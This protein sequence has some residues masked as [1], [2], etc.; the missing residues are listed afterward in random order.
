MRNITFRTSKFSRL[1]FI[2]SLFLLNTTLSFAQVCGTPGADGPINASTSINTYYPIT[3]TLNL[4]KGAKTIALTAV[5]AT[6]SHGNNFGGTQISSGDLV[7]IIQMQDASIDYSNNPNYGSG[8]SSSGIDGLGG[9]GFTNLGNTGIYEY[10]IATSNVPLTGGTLT[11]IGTGTGGGALNDY[12]NAAPTTTSGKKTFQIIRVPQF[13]NLTLNSN[14]T[15]PPFNGFAGGIIAFNVSGTFNFNG[16]N[17]DGSARGFRGG[18]SPVAATNANNST[19]YVDNSTSSVVSGKGEGIAGTPRYMWDGF[20]Q[21]NNG[22]EGMPG[23]SAGRGAPANAGGGGNDHN[24]GGGGGGNGGN[25]G[26]GGLGWQ[27]GG[28]DVSPLNGGGR[29]GYTSYLTATPSLTRLVMGGGGGAGDANNAVNGV[30]GG[31]GGAIILINAGSIQGTGNIYA[32]G[33][34]GA[35][36]TYSGAPDGAGGGGAGGSV[37]LNISNNST[38]TI[39]IEAKGGN[40][41]NTLNDENNSHGPG[42]G[43]GGGIIRYNVPGSGVTINTS[44]IN[45]VSGVTADNKNHGAQ[46]GTVGYVSTFSSSDMPSELQINSNCLA[47]LSTKVNSINKSVC[48]TIDATVTYEIEIT[49]LGSGNAAQVNLNYLFPTGINFDSATATYTLNASG[50]TGSMANTGTANSPIVGGF[51]IPLNGVVKITLIG[52]VAAAMT[53]GTTYSS[54]AQA[55]YLDPTRTIAD[56][57]RRITPFTNSFGTVNT[58]YQTGGG[59]NVGGTNFDGTSKTEDDVLVIASPGTPSISASG[60][61]TFCAGG[62]VVLSS[63]AGTGYLWSTGATTQTITV[64]TS[65]TYTVKVSNASGCYSASSAGTTVTANP[66]P[67]AYNVTGGGAYCAGGT[68]VAVGLSNSQTGVSYQ[69]KLA[70][71]NDGTAV[72]GTGSAI[73]FGTKTAAG[74]YTVV[75]TNSTTSCTATMTGSA[76]ISI[77]PLPTAYNVTGG[78]TYCAGGTGFAIGLSNS[79][80]GVSYQLQLGGTNNGTAVAGTGSAISFGTKTAAGTYTVVATNTTTSCTAPMTG[81]ATITVNPLPT[82]YN[83][84]GGGSY[85]TGGTGFAVGLSNSQSGVSYQLKLAGANDG[86]AVAGTGSAISFGT[87]TAAG[88]Y[89]VVATNTTTSC[90]ATMTG[91]ATITINP[92]PTAYNVTGGGAYCAGG[93]GVAV[94]LSNSQTGVSYQLQLAGANDGTAVAGTGSAISFGTKTAAGNYTVVATNTTTSCT[95]PMTGSV[96]ITVN[97]LPT[98]YNVTGGGSYCAGGTGVAVGLSNSQTG[99]SYQLQLA[100]AND[101]TVVAGTGS[102]ISFGTKTAAGNYTVVATNTTTSCTAPM[103]GS[104]TIT[105]NPLP[106]AY[107]VTG[108]GSYCAGGTGVA[109]GL[110]NSQTG[111]SYQLQLAGANDGTAVAGTGSAISFGTKTAAGTYTVVAT[112]TTTSCTAP[113][114]GSVTIT[115]NPLPTTYNVTG[116]GSYCAGG[117]GVAVGLS[118]SQT[119]VSYQ[120]QLAGANDGT[121]V[122]GTG[123]AISFGTKTA[124]GNYTVVATNTTTS[125]TAPM[126]GSVTI[127]INPLP[128]AYNVTGGGSYCAG[129]TGVAVGLSNS[130]TGVSYQLQLA[131]AN[132]GTAVAGTG[133]AISFGTRTAAGNYTV[134]ATNTTT[135]CTAP[136]TGSVTI[137]VNPL[138]TAYNVTGGG[139]YCAG[140]TGVAVG[141]SNSQTG[142]SY[143]LQLAGA[144]DGTAVAGTGSA[145][146]FGTK[147]AAGNYTVVATN[148]TT[149]CTAPMTGSV[150]ITINPLPTAYN[151]TGG[152]AYCAG[153]TGV[154][155]GLSNSQTGVSY[156]LQLAG[157]ND[158]TAVAGTGS[159]ISFGTKTAAGNYTVV[160]TNT[161]TSCTAPMTGSVTITINPLPTAYNVTGGGAYCA[162]GTGVAVGLSNSQ[163]GVSYQLQLAGANDGTAV[164]GTGSAISFGTKTA[165][166]NYT[167]VATNT[168]TSC[169]A[170]MTGSV[171]I[172]VNPLPTAYNVTGGGAYC[173]GGTG[174]AV[175]LSNSQTGVSYQLQL[176]GA[177]DGTAVAGTG[178]AIS[179]GT[180]TAT[181]NYTVVATNSTTSCTAPMSGSVTIS[182][183]PLP[184]KPVTSVTQPN[185]NT[186]TGSI[187]VTVQDPLETYSFDNGQN[188]QSGNSKS[189]LTPGSYDVIIKNTSGCN[190]PKNTVTINVKPN[191]PPV[192]VDD[193]ATATEDTLYTSTVSLVTNDTDVDSSPLTV[194]AGTYTT[195]KG[196]T[197]T[198]AADGSYTYM[199]APNFNG[200]DTVDY[201]VTDGSLTDIG[202]LTITVNAVNDAPIAV[203]DTATATED[204]LY[205]STVSLV[206]NDTDV[207]SSP[208][209][210]I[211]GTYTTT[212]GGTLTLAADGSYTYMPAPN[213]SGTDTVDYTVTDGSLTDIGTLTITVN[214]VNDAPVAVDDTATVTEDTLYTSTVSLVANDTDV[215]SSPLT[216][217]AGTY[218]TTKGG[219]LTLAADGSYTYMPPANFSGTD[220]VDYTVTDG[221]LTDIGTLT[222]TVNAVNDAPIAVD[223]T[224]TATEDTLYTSTV[225]L[226]ANDTDVDSS[227][228]TVIAGTYTTTKGGTLT[229]AA[230][231]SYTYMPAPNFSGTD[232]VDYTVTDGSLTDIGTLTITVNAVNDAPI[233]VDDT[234]TATEDTLYTSIVSLVANDTDVDSSPLTVI[235][236]TY[237]TTKGGTLTLVAD[238][239][240]TYMPAPNFS[241]TDTVDYTVTDGSLTDIGTLTIT[242]NAVND[243]PIAVDDTA[244]ATEDTLYTSTV[245]LVANDT[246]VDSSPLTV[247]AGTYTTTK[248]GTLTLAADGS[249]TYMPAPNFSGTDTVDYTVT[250]GSLTD[251]GTLTITVNAV[252]D[253]PIAVD[254]TA[255]ATEDTLYTSTVSLVA[256]DTDVDSSPLTVIAGTYTTTK[257]GTLTL[258]A[259]GS[260]TYMPAPNFNG[261]DTVDYTVT[262]GSLTDVGALTIT[263]NAVNDAPIAVDD[264]ATATEDTLYTSTVSLVAND[265]DVD[266]SPLTVV[267]G[268]YTTVKGGTLTLAADGSYT[269]MPAPNFNGTDTVDYTVTDGSLTDIGTLTITV[270]AVNDAPIAVDDTAT[271]TEDTLYTST[272]SLVANDTDVDSSPLT[273]IA[274]TYTTTK[275]GT[276]TLAADGSYT[277]MPPA[278]FN[279]TDTVDYTVTDGSL[280]DIGT[281][282]ITVNAVNDAPIAVDDTATA[283]EDTLYTSTVSLVANDTDVDS[284]PL[285]VIAGTYT[286][287]KGGT[288][289]LAA[290]G[291][292]TYMPAPNFN[293][294]DTVDY[295]VTDGSLTDIGTLTI[296]V[297]AVNDAPIA[298]DDT[299]TATED[300]LYTSSISLVANDTDVDS[301]PLTVIAGTYTTAKGG[302]LTLAADGSYTYMPPANFSGT[303]TVDYTVTDG[304]LTDIGTLTIT[305][306]AVND[307]PVAV[308]D[309]ATAT[310]DTLYT[311]TVSLVANDTDVDSSPLTV[312]AGTYTTTKGGT[313]TLAADGSYTYMPAPNFNGTDT[314]DY[315]VTDGSLTD[316][317]T[318]T[319]TVNAVNDAPIA[320]DDT[321]TATEDTLYTSTVSLVANDTD[322][323]SSP[324]T[325]IA[326]TYTTAKGGTLTLAADG[327]YT[328]MPP[329]N[330]SGTDTVDYTVTDGSLT[331]IGTLTITVNAVND[332]PVAVDDTAT[333]TEDTLYT[334]TVS[335]VAN[336]T[337]VDSSPLTVIA[338]TYT[339]TKGGTLTLAA[340]GSYTYMPAPNFNGTDTVDYTVTDG[341]LTDIGTL[342]ITV[343]PVNDAPIAVDDTATATEDTLY[344]SMVSLV[345]NDTDVDSS[346]LTVIAGTYTTA[347]GGTLTLAADGSYTYMPAPNFNGTDT[348]DYTVT[349]GSLTDVGT[350]TI[351]VNAVNDAPIAVDDTA[352]VTEDTLYTS[353]VSLVANDT[354]VDSSPL[355][356]VA[357]TYTTTKGGTLTLAADGSYTYMP[358]PNFNG[359][360]TVDYTVTDGSLTDVGT[361]TITV[362][363]V[364][365]APVAVDDTATA[366]E[367][368]LYTSTVSLVAND[369]DV[370]S[371][372]LTVVAGTYTT[373][374]GG[375]L[376]LA[377]DGSYTYMP[378]PNFNG[379]DTVDY[380]VTDGSLTDIGT[381]TITVNAVNDAPVAVDDTATATEDTLYTS[382]VSLVANDTDVDS[383]PLTVIAGT[384]TTTKGGTLT[385]AADGSYTYMPAPNFNGTDTVDY[386]VTDGSLTDVGTLTIT[387]NAVNDAPV[388]VDDTATAT[389][390]T[391]YTSTVS[392]VANDTDVDSSPLTVVAG[393]YTTTK[394]GTLTL[395]SDGSYTYMPAP[396]FNGTD[397]VDYTVTDGS[398]TDIG[399]LTIT[400]NAVNDAPVAVDDTATATEDTLYTSTVSLVANDTDVDSSPLTVVAGTYTTTKGGTLILAADGSYTYMP[401]ANFSGIDTVDYTVTDGSLTD[402]GTL[403]ITVNAVNH[404]PIAVDNSNTTNEDTTLTV[405]VTSSVNLLANDT[406]SDG[407][408]LTITQFVIGTT[409]Y[410]VGSTANLAEG[411]LTINANGSYTFVPKAD[412]NGSVP[413]V[414]YTV[415]DG[416]TSATANLFIT[417]TPVNDAPIAVDDTATATEDTLY[418]SIVSLVANDTDVDSSPLTVIAGTYTTVKGGTLTLAA[419][420]SYTY[421]P[422]PNFSG[423]DT[424][425]YTVTDGSLT[426]I[427]TLTITVNAVNDAPIAV[428][429]TA[430][431]TEDTLY[432][433]T[434]S[435]VANDTDVDSSPL[436]VIAGTYTT[437]KGG[438]LTLAADGSYTYMPPANFSGTD[439]VDYTV[440]DGS[441]T[442]IGTLTITV[443]AVNHAPIAVDNSNTTNEDTTLTVDVTS[444][445]NLLANDTDADGDT[446]TITQFVI[447]TTTY[448]VGSTANLAEG[449]LTINA[450]G[451]YVFIPKADYNG[452]V[453]KVTYTV[454]DGTSS[455]TANLFITVTPVNDAPIAVDDTATATEDTL[456]TSS[457]SLV[458]ND[459]DVDSSPLTVIAGTYT[460]AKGGTLTLAADGSYTYMPAPNFN[461]TDTVDYTV[462]DGSLTDIGTLTITVNAV[463]DAPIA[464]DDTATAT[465]DTLY[466]STVS[467][468]AND[469]DVDS[470]PLTVVA[471][472]Y[473]TAKGGTLT[474]AADGSYTYMPAPNF[475]GT[476]TVDYTVTDGSLTDV[477]TLTITVTAVNDAPIAVD[478]TATATEDTL[479]TSTVSLV[480]N[481]TDV[482]SSPLTVIAGTYTTVKGGTLTLAADGSYTYM[483]PANFSGTDTVDYTVTDGSLTDIGTLTITVNAV[484]DAPVAVDDTA[485]A[486]EDTLYTSTVSLVANDTDVDSSPLTVIAGTYTTTKGGTL[487]LAADGSYT[488]MPAPNFNGTDTVDYTV[489]DGSLTDIGTLTITV[490]AVN[491]APVAV[492]N[493]NTTNE[494][495]T[496]TVAVTSSANLLANDTDADGDTL[497]ITQ[498]VIGTTTYTVGSTANLA[499]GDLTI[500]ANGSYVFI[501]KADYNGSVPKVTY[502]VTDGTSS[503][504]ANLFITV[505][506]VN[507]APIAVDDTA[508]ATEDTL[509][510][511][512]VSLVA[513]DTDV[514]SSSLTVVA[515][516]Y[517]TAKGGTLTL[518]ADGSYTYM[519]APNFNGTDTVDYTVTDG[520]L[521]DIGTLTITVNAVNDA[522]IAVDDTATATEDTLYTST[523]SLVANDT[524]VDSSPLTVVAGTYTTTKGGTLTLAADGSYTYMP[525]PNFNGTDTVDYTVTDGSL[526]DIG[527]LTITVNAVNDAPIAVDDTATAIEDTLYTSTVSLVANDTDVDSSPLTVV[528]GTY[529]TTKGGTLTLATDG[530]YTYMPAPNFN[531]TDTVD[532]TVTDGSL[533]DIGTLTITVTAVNHAPIAV[534]NSNT[535]NED[536]TLTVDVTSSANLLAND[537]DADGDTLTITQFVIGTTTYPVGSTANLAEGD[538]T[539][540][541]NGSYVFIPKADYNGSVPKVTYT[542]TD[543]TSSATANLF[544]TVTPVNDAP[545]AVDDTATATEDTLYTSS[546]S[547]VANDT[548]VDSSPLTVVA[549][550]YTTT[551]G[552]TLTLA[553]DG[554]YTYMPAPNF[555]GTDTVDYTVTDGSLTDIGTL[556]ITVNAVND[557]PIAVDDTATATEDTLYTSTV[558]LVAN[559]TDVDSSPLTVVAGTY[560][561]VKGGT[562]TLAADGSYTYMPAPNFNGTDTVDYTVTDGSLTDIGTLTITV[563]AVN[564]AP[565]AV[566]DTATATEDTLYTSTVSLVANDTDVDSSPLT[567]IAGTYT[568]T[569]GGTLTL[570]ADGSYTYMPAPNFNGTD[571]VDYT[572]TDGSLTDVGTLTITVNAVNDAPIAVDDTATATE[573]TLYTSTVSFVVNDTDVDSSPLT[574]VAGTYTTTKGGTLTLAADGSYTYMPAPNF[575]G[576]DTVDY[577]VTDGSLTDIGTLTITVTAVN[578]APVAVDNSNT[579]NEDTTLTVAVTSSAN[580]LANDTDPDGDTLTITQFVIGTTTYTVGSTANLA[581]GDL[582]INANGSYTFVPKAD[583]NG[584]VPKVTYT[585]TDGTSSATAN[586]FITVIPV[587]DAPVAVDNSNTTNEDTTLTVDVTSSANLLA[588]DTDVDGDTL[589]ITQFVIGTTTYP[590]GSTANLAEGDLTINANGSYVFVPKADYNGSVPKVTY[591]V[592]DG[593]ST[594]TANLF[595]TVIPVNDTIV[596]KDDTANSVVSTNQPKT[597][598][599]VLGNDTK[600]GQPI[601]STDVDIKETVS[602]PTGNIKLNPDGTVVLKPNAPSG[603]YELTYQVCELNTTNCGTATV[604]ITVVAPVI[605][606][607]S[608]TTAPINGNIGGTTISLITNDTLNGGSVVIGN[609][610][611]QVILTG[612]NV[613]TGLTLNADGTVTVAPGTPKGDYQVEYR[614]CE[615]NDPNNCDTAISIIQVTGA[616]LVLKDDSAGSVVSTNQPKTILNVLGNDTKNGLPIV[617]TDVDIKETVSDPTGNIKLNPDGTV[618]LKP[619]APSG[620]YELTY[621]VCE[622]NT[623]NCGTATVKV[624]VVAPVIN[625]VSETTAPI[626]GNIGGTTISLITNDTLNGGS[627][628]IGNQVGQVILTGIN[629]PTGLTLNAD[630]T[631]TVAPGTP[632]GD[633]QVEYRICEANDPNNCDTAISIIPVTGAVIVLKDDSAGSVVGV[634][635]PVD[636]L[637]V[638]GNDTKNGQPIVSTDVDI[639]ETVSDPTG[640]IKL[641]PDGTIVLGP[642][643]PAGTYE[644]TY[645]VCELNTTNCAT[646]TVTVTVVAPTMTITADS[647][648]SNNV[649]YVS[650][651][652]KPDNFTPNNLLTI[653]WIDSANNVVATQTNLPLSGNILWPGATVDSNGNGL[654]WPGWV[655]TNGQWTEGA[656]GFENTRPSVTMEFSLNPTAKVVVNYPVATADCNA[657]PAFVIKANDDQAGPINTNKEISTSLNI[658]N[659]DT[660]NG[661]RFNA[662]NVTLT[663]II[664]NPNLVLNADGSVDLVPKTP[665]G[666]YQ[667]TYQIC[668]AVNAGNC[669]QAVVTVTVLNSL[670]PDPPTPLILTNDK[671]NVDGINGELEFINVL[672]NDLLKGLPINIADVVF[673]PS[674][675]PYFEF[676]ADGTV[677]VKPNTPG[678]DYTLTYQVCEKANP[679][680]CKTA[681]L[682]VFVEVPSIAIIKT[683]SFND[684]N[685]DKVAEAGETIT[686]KFKVTNTGNVALT[687]VMIKDLLPG[688]VISG[689]AFDLEPN[690]SNETNFTAEYKITQN[691]INHGS[692]TNQ[693]SVEGKSGK[694]V[695]VGDTSDKDNNSEDRPTVIALNGCEIKVFNAFSPNGDSKNARFYIQGLECYPDNTVEIYNRW[696]V[697][698]YDTNNYNNEDRVFVGISEGR[699]TIKQSDGLPV[700]TYFYILK[701]KDS[702]SNQ[703]E[704]SGYLY[705]NK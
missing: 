420:G 148:T 312:I 556:T 93:T 92:L 184:A 355:T 173:A 251:V 393:T 549:G 592:T 31:V 560:T 282:T 562:L 604:K 643:A 639:K 466:T 433:S 304:S 570:A 516:T 316:I 272:V 463:N 425:D 380:T 665:S 344:T 508:T 600:N 477:G 568:T 680:N 527:T 277:Y 535:T 140:G 167:V 245:S 351:T 587:N 479:Y 483:P 464:V 181:G 102:A 686:Y 171:T 700:G 333:A 187:T 432:T 618:V 301:S 54:K 579:T 632:K 458:A 611:G 352:T 219:T 305:V 257:G 198:L 688:L 551:K 437:T 658:F 209:T 310:E 473:T 510:T 264:T 202:T 520:S 607:V 17:I 413:K 265:T 427:G 270:N 109:V 201:T 648:C 41:G 163:T 197:L 398:L 175:G 377:S 113:M 360:D 89:T 472:T 221:S 642:N 513:N 120:L 114:T 323:D 138:P 391:L 363:A 248:G 210:V 384:Y 371:S 9:T 526:T 374:K 546:I 178:S 379:T 225:S 468:V 267:A 22:V 179:F 478:D 676:N 476:D 244:T 670:D 91:S 429:D 234:A 597:I 338:G 543:G 581:E 395:A 135:S 324:L 503:A 672:D 112:N 7:L 576:T 387:V 325:V 701:Y 649:P 348:V 10:V 28:G 23:G 249:Y 475:S 369:T 74:T 422:A 457:I 388:A 346:P 228:L 624:T 30:K 342:T 51:N 529:T 638:L 33:G 694:G 444:S 98:A 24:S 644:L 367:D 283:T 440:T 288:L 405:A 598:L 385:L 322:V 196:G 238:G 616:D 494:D 507:D 268:T 596:I 87:K 519:P 108:G 117:T 254:D 5:P 130:Q 663:T 237:T 326:G 606:A 134:V 260:Y 82:A 505:T 569:K 619:N 162:G 378:A 627:V 612:I 194:I 358:A 654:D 589:T 450:N 554:S 552:G 281:L 365:D 252:N 83:V 8:S 180:K 399:T 273:V 278:N 215:D 404:A 636:V 512:T 366:T 141:L 115:V 127:T 530:S 29:P 232:T 193:T 699:T 424:V 500:N 52:K 682:I 357:G 205:T 657:R 461:G 566:D 218:T 340:D 609:Q 668:D 280:T 661:T 409:T 319:I 2:A 177:N 85:C 553:A 625:A 664:A 302:T 133:S 192:A 45:G 64:T 286:T 80:S 671:I 681:T 418:T 401:P 669:S 626:N 25:G 419:D 71:A 442:D 34:V 276:L 486:T 240:Y 101:G 542:V 350:L 136:M 454:T 4:A 104:A 524:D 455:A 448:P 539:I 667:L 19:T 375:T 199:P 586:L 186:F 214:A 96:T 207:D 53:P 59:L 95:A 691:D 300:T 574:V 431:A 235:A 287:V 558:S 262:D 470:S 634:N 392:L 590:V 126:T 469:T 370:D 635:H 548:D 523:V 230:D 150:T 233:A 236:G 426:D 285:T 119:G 504:T 572:V 666:T 143:Q 320:V 20:N 293:G 204:T 27:G 161:T 695:V 208:L 453:P 153:G 561:T 99:V 250:D 132:D 69:L 290:D 15:T 525:A 3:G 347:K 86:T 614:I 271:A 533:T 575:N 328:Y 12:F 94:G 677:N 637:N 698:V 169:T 449:D 263:V 151:V 601:V 359:T 497:T 129:G 451:S 518:A 67:T 381:L 313:L 14:I 72:A 406:D 172:T 650:Y 337:D 678:G 397:T 223:D 438:T 189:G 386:T 646:A 462:T 284:S 298:V 588:N 465:E 571:T 222:I 481:D 213:F 146:S 403:T 623:T 400:V 195:T 239:S 106:T 491:H 565:I 36:G 485:T 536:T 203:D 407:D 88:T 318:L 297:N 66:L 247:V 26:L 97:P 594:A 495:T 434:V 227:P 482:D 295:T 44:V 506:P 593:T 220:T 111:V 591:T 488:Y 306:N 602:D 354:D 531:G 659:N 489:T 47:S 585:I 274:G 243:A 18:Y 376:T 299:A 149:S 641:N 128:T 125:C 578:H 160:A 188:F 100:G 145:I 32:N 107:N 692:V 200:T 509:Y 168:T 620:T 412:Y 705:I 501:P 176:A 389:E 154:A 185:C 321:A 170:P 84:T 43:G 372:P 261:T 46:P 564:D 647:Y 428:D 364:N 68:G 103:T 583:Y 555:N 289:T 415:T 430:T 190:S 37:F 629:V 329:A 118:N 253:A 79:Q 131:G 356:V 144:N 502:T 61:T 307:A 517:T 191:C 255:T 573:D 292:Y 212:K 242:V 341:S 349:D 580:L 490:T 498:F 121:A 421:M 147:T 411:D 158:G 414:T 456:Y 685:G 246:D 334:S 656:D 157:A 206:A 182:T 343:T 441:L 56:P 408:T 231:G 423:T 224:A 110:S 57:S 279:G 396:N 474:L 39:N 335:L 621:Q 460:T 368:T 21:V 156:Q 547:L 704:L 165:T 528:A 679:Q 522:P 563:N 296:T 532:Y 6:D 48:N 211:A 58:T 241:G 75:A 492:D 308:D 311:S 673:T 645:Q 496:L 62:S 684:E 291:S 605:D 655:L 541:A 258:A 332:A 303:D 608:E 327:S 690:E 499:E 11:F 266:S 416:T 613:P 315:T 514:D 159:A 155:V 537:T 164:A 353:T 435:L 216:V 345:A 35:A 538:L 49:N 630:G 577:T 550:T 417:V 493:S 373:T 617:S 63:T 90:T 436:T 78:G 139:A 122:A 217:V 459:T 622:L 137:T 16:F 65:G 467:L 567:V 361:L 42:G 584:T 55:L 683:A 446:L 653:T 124:A 544:I 13:S 116:G 603:T 410:P 702:G 687:Q 70:G 484:N 294:T 256:N 675:S 60:P 545:I 521:T 633:Y 183:N 390:D 480:A 362:N 314:V 511:S 452:S 674:T 515:G 226:V 152:G 615:A 582:T 443:T 38:T 487:T 689:Q 275:G 317:G 229:L 40:G 81:N 402:I 540:N 439:T 105:V 557:A 652:V 77:N 628:V 383:S 259:D 631:V 662:S 309:T 471:G 703:H 76:T 660:L 693:A 394:G 447:G 610:V 559:D 73:S 174:V 50:P 142:V 382:T 534:D 269:Y 330:F 696:G 445:A 599:N 595:I 123:S 336:D 1:I 339:T 331:D 640:N 651:N 166:G 697:L